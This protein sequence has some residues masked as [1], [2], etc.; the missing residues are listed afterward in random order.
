M[1]KE[2]LYILTRVIFV[3]LNSICS[4][5]L[6]L[7]ILV[8]FLPASLGT[9]VSYLSAEITRG[10]WKPASMNGTDWPNPDAN[11]S[12]VMEKIKTIVSAT[13]VHVPS[14]T[15]GFYFLSY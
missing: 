2:L 9:I 7:K 14:A 5:I 13:A 12:S 10:I 4:N 1:I 6:G 3:L 15:S 8:D 11:L